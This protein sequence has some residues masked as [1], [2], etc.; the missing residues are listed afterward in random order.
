[1]VKQYFD[2]SFDD[3][4]DLTELD[5]ENFDGN[6]KI[7]G[8]NK[9]EVKIHAV[10]R[11]TTYKFGLLE[12]AEELIP[13]IKIRVKNSGDK[14]LVKTRQ[15]RFADRYEFL[16][17]FVD[18]TIYAPKRLALK[19]N[20]QNGD[21]L[22]DA[23]YG[24]LN[25]GTSDGDVSLS[26]FEGTMNVSTIDGNISLYDVNG[27]IDASTSQGDILALI[28]PGLYTSLRTSA[29]NVDLSFT[30]FKKSKPVIMVDNTDG[31][32]SSNVPVVTSVS[33]DSLTT[34]EHV[35]F[36]ETTHGNVDIKSESFP[37]FDSQF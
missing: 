36:I 5:I 31:I 10:R 14:I 37:V 32:T 15:P 25:V 18:I 20:N 1:M 34:T 19:A 23:F 28:Q 29:G 24:N 9:E 12:K 22:V 4:S 26:H 27:N 6:I 17:S 33:D 13:Q 8:W 21:V 16:G 7:Q 2:Y 35:V 30:D 11:V 3:I